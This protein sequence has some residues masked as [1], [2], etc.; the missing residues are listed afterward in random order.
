MLTTWRN[1]LR[2]ASLNTQAHLRLKSKLRGTI[3]VNPF[4]DDQLRRDV[5]REKEKQHEQNAIV[6]QETKE[7]DQDQ[8]AEDS[9]HEEETEDEVSEEEESEV[10]ECPHQVVAAGGDGDDMDESEGSEE[11]EDEDENENEDENEEKNEEKN[12][13]DEDMEEDGPEP[14]SKRTKKERHNRNALEKITQQTVEKAGDQKKKVRNSTTHKKEWMLSCVRFP[15]STYSR[16]HWQEHFWRTKPTSSDFGWTVTKMGWKC[17]W[18]LS[19]NNR[20][21]QHGKEST[22]SSES[23]GVEKSMDETKYKALIEKRMSQGL[24]YKDTDFPEDEEDLREYHMRYCWWYLWI[25]VALH[26]TFLNHCAQNESLRNDIRKI[27][28]WSMVIMILIHCCS[29]HCI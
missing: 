6:A 16:R 26:L 11:D 9:E 10:E 29:K 17:R 2:F 15:T 5:L 13:D 8:E 23:T 22:S 28:S 19:E 4:K 24:W 12:D 25:S 21:H 7:D 14:E 3:P 1:S 20:D 27:Q 18:W